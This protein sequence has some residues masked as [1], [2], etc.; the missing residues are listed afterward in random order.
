MFKKEE[1]ETIIYSDRRVRITDKQVIIGASLYPTRY[2]MPN[3]ISVSKG[4]RPP[5]RATGIVVIL[6]GVVILATVLFWSAAGGSAIASIKNTIL[7]AGIALGVIA[8]AIGIW[9]IITVKPAYTVMLGTQNG[10]EEALASR[11]EA[12]VERIVD[13]MKRACAEYGNVREG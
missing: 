3:I 4:M 12:Y 7:I 5:K 10:Q 2:R 9:D 8:L 6:L 1:E 13:V 11:D